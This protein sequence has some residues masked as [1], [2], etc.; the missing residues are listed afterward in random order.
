ME[1]EKLV[2]I[3]LKGVEGMKGPFELGFAIFKK[4]L[5]FSQEGITEIPRYMADKILKEFPGSYE[6]V[7]EV[8]PTKQERTS[9]VDSKS[10]ETKE[11]AKQ[12]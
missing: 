11:F 6:V 3:R 2:K 7:Q 9:K 8:K 1:P 4:K 12:M 5:T 10:D